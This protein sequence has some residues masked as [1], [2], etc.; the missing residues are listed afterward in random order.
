M[1]NEIGA[2]VADSFDFLV[3]SKKR[4]IGLEVEPQDGDPFILPMSYETT[5]QVAMN[6]LKMLLFHAPE[7]AQARLAAAAP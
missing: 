7:M 4:L 5:E 1:S 6:I 3:D 2:I